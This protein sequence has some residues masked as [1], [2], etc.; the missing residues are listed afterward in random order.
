MN[1]PNIVYIH[2]HDTGRYVQPYGYAIP[3]P[4]YQRLAEEGV[5]F[6]QAFCAAPTCSPSRAALL[7]GQSPHNAG[8]LGLA[9]RGFSMADYRQH[10]CHLL[11]PLGYETVLAGFEHVGNVEKQ[12]YDHVGENRHDG[13]AAIATAKRF[14]ES[15]REQPLFLDVGFTATHRKG[16][17]FDPPPDGQP[18]TDPRYVAPPPVMP[19]D[20][21]A[22]ED[23]AAYIDS[24][25]LL[26]RQVGQVLETID[27][28][29]MTDNTLV[30]LTTDHG[31]AFPA[32]KCNLTTHGMGVLLIMRGP[33]GFTGGKVSDGLVS[34]ID[35]VPTLCE[36]LGTD[37]PP[38]VQ[39]RTLMPLVRGE[40]EEVNEQVYGEVTYHAALQPMRSV[41]SRRY[42]YVRRFGDY[43]EPVMP[44]VDDSVSKTLRM[45]GGWRQQRLPDEELYDLL[46]DPNEAH[47]LARD[48][49]H[50]EALVDMRRRLDDWMQ[51][52]DDPLLQGVPV[53]SGAKVNDH[54]GT[55]PNE[56]AQMLA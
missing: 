25:R 14:L 8:M 33:G 18:K 21:V 16:T 52:T 20:P 45:G 36:V 51:R 46:F 6:R 22:R 32:M 39:G 11:K 48:P 38:W 1:T 29:G 49:A 54:R 41:R 26:D 24:A 7:T 5:L 4:A 37:P 55:S 31:I 13:D 56:P 43:R 40:T 17:G 50:G 27:Q 10:L 19:D 53:P 47:N 23:M 12:G 15:G 42:N 30:I 2:S 28:A 44:N 9:H 35:I 34:H 3:T